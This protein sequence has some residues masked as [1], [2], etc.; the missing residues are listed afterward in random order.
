MASALTPTIRLT[1]EPVMAPI[2]A[3]TAEIREHTVI[4]KQDQDPTDNLVCQENLANTADHP[5][6]ES[7]KT[8]IERKSVAVAARQ[9]GFC[10]WQF[11]KET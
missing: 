2:K 6:Y 3:A 10:H 11:P 9:N 1:S 7:T 4:S 8:G 5:L